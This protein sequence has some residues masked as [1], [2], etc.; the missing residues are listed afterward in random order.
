MDDSTKLTA[1]ICIAVVAVVGLIATIAIFYNLTQADIAAKCV[2]S[3][4]SWVWLNAAY[5]CVAEVR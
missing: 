5:Q 4:K 2:T 3:G 1:C